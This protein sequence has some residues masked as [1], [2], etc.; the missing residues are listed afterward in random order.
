M[1]HRR[2]PHAPNARAIALVFVA[3]AA[4][5]PGAQVAMPG[6]LITSLSVSGYGSAAASGSVSFYQPGTLVP[7][8]AVYSDDA[9]TQIV[10][11]PITLDASGR[12][13]VPLYVA[14][15]ARAIVKAASGAT[16]AD[17]ARIDGDRAELV[18]LVNTTWPSSTTVDQAL[19]ALAGSLG[20]TNGR[21]L[22]AGSGAVARTIQAKFAE[23]QISVKDFGAV[24][25]GIADDYVAIQA[26]IN[27]ATALG[28]GVVYF[29]P[30]TYLTSSVPVVTV[31]GVDIVGAGATSSIIKQTS[32]ANGGISFAVASGSGVISNRIATIQLVH[33]STSTGAALAQSNLGSVLIDRCRIGAGTYRTG[34]LSTASAGLSV[35]QGSYI[36][37]NAA[38]AS[39]VG[40]NLSGGGSYAIAGSFITGAALHAMQLGNGTFTVTGNLIQGA[41]AAA[42]G[43]LANSAST[44]LEAAGNW[45]SAGPSGHAVS[46]GASFTGDVHIAPGQY[47]SPDILDA[48]SAS[49]A[50]VGYSF[51]TSQAFT[52]L[53]LQADT[54]RVVATA[55]ITVT[56][57]AIAPTGFGRRWTLMCLNSS[58]GVVV[59]TF[60]AQYVL[61]AAVAPATG[62][63]VNL[64]LEYDPVSG[65]IREIG[66][67]ATAI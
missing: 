26:A 61:S 62:N 48:R 2:S 57:G 53:P 5:S 16:L 33:A 64:S 8:A 54:V 22:D 46:I 65:K 36:D 47:L 4:C 21:F 35:I 44:S 42:N 32:A 20:G 59:W 18:G 55:A 17:Y 50:P 3:F 19:T 14:A 13:P 7:M 31:P 34:F 27:R 43:I 41:A 6:K 38:D 24:G 30:G 56:V 1:P 15:S 51:G 23:V 37:A 29:P 67:A 39:S 45:I 60:N 66:R 52:P 58:G 12:S 11:Q 28:G 63:M 10:S 49:T 25:N 9:M 40:V